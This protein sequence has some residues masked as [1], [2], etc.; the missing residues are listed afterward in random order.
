MP[1]F[2]IKVVSDTKAAEENLK[3]LDAT[4]NSATKERKL[5]IDTSGLVK[6]IEGIKNLDIGKLNKG[7]N[8]IQ[9][10]VKEAANTIQQFY[11]IGKQLPT[12]LGDQIRQYEQLAKGTLAVAKAAPEATVALKRNAEA[13]QILANSYTAA[14]SGATKLVENLAKVGFAM[15]GVQQA[16]GLVKGA[17]QGFF[18]ETIGREIQFRETLLKTQTTLAST[19]KVFKGNKEITDP[20]EK[21]VTL[22]GAIKERIKSIEDRSI[23]LAGVTSNDVVEVFGIISSQIGN[24]GGGL[25]EA[26]D[27]AISF[28]A[29]LGTFGIPLYQARQEIGSILRGQITEDSYL[30]KALGI[31]S[32]DVQKAK[33]QTGGVVAFIQKKLEASVAGQKIAAKGFSGITSNIND[34]FQIFKKSFGAGL[35]DP[36]LEGLSKTYN[37]LSSLKNVVKGISEEL[38]KSIGQLFSRN[39]SSIFGGSDLFKGLSSSTTGFAEQFASALKRAFTSLQADINDFIAPV[40]NLFEELVKSAGVL[41][42]G[43]TELGKGFVS[44]KIEE[45]KALITIFSNLSEIATVFA[46][47]LSQVL[48]VYGKLLQLPPVQAFAQLRAEID[49]LDKLGVTKIIQFGVVFVGLIKPF[50]LVVT[51]FRTLVAKI[52]GNLSEIIGKVAAAVARITAMIEGMNS[53]LAAATSNVA[54]TAATASFTARAKAKAGASGGSAAV[55]SF[56][57]AAADYGKN[58]TTQLNSALA[59]PVVGKLQDKFI[60]IGSALAGAA[61]PAVSALKKEVQSLNTSFTNTG[62]I[63]SGVYAKLQGLGASVANNIVPAFSRVKDNVN[64]LKA[65]IATNNVVPFRVTDTSQASPAPQTLSASPSPKVSNFTGINIPV[66]PTQVQSSYENIK[67]SAI[68]VGAAFTAVAAPAG[69]AKQQLEDVGSSSERAAQS[70]QGLIG[71]T[72]TL[73]GNFVQMGQGLEKTSQNLQKFSQAATNGGKAVSLAIG[74]AAKAMFTFVKANLIML[75]IQVTITALINVF[76]HFQRQQEAIARSRKAEDAL[77]ELNTKYKNVTESSSEA[78]KA[79][80]AYLESLVSGEYAA[81]SEQLDDL[82]AKQRAQQGPNIF[83]QMGNGVKYLIAE[84]GKLFTTLKSF[85]AI[86]ASPLLGGTLGALLASRVR[87]KQNPE[88]PIDHKFF[89]FDTRNITDPMGRHSKDGWY[90]QELD[91]QVRETAA[92]KAR[93]KPQEEGAG[94][95]NNDVTT[96]AQQQ[97][98]NLERMQQ[99]E[100]EMAERRRAFEED[101]FDFRKSQEDVIF[102]RR[103]ALAQKE[104]DI[105]RASGELRIAQMERSNAKALEGEEGASRA[106]LEALNTYLFER[107]KGELDIEAQKKELSLEVVKVERALAD[108]RLSQ[109][110][111]IAEIRR[112]AEKYALD[113]AKA[114]QQLAA[115]GTASVGGGGSSYTGPGSIQNKLLEAANS[116]LGLFAGSSERCADAM[117]ELFEVAGVA[118]GTTKKAWD[119]LE[120]GPSLA[121]SFFGSDI[122]QKITKKEDLRPGDL[123]GFDRTYGNWKKGVQTHVGMYAGDN[124]MYDHSSKSGLVKRSLDTFQGKFLYGVRPNAY[125][126]GQS[127]NTG[128]LATPPYPVLPPP[129]R[130]INNNNVKADTSTLSGKEQFLI[131]ELIRR[132]FK[133]VQIAAIMGS[134]KTES[135]LNPAQ[136]QIGGGDGLGLFQWSGTRRS[137]VPKITGDYATDV[138]NQLDLF[139]KELSTTHKGAGDK[140]KSATTLEA[141]GAGMKQFEL[142]GKAG[143]RYEYMQDYLNRIQKGQFQG[144]SAAGGTGVAGSVNIPELPDFS[145]LNDPQHLATV[146]NLDKAML[147]MG[148]KLQNLKG[149]LNELNN[150]TNFENIGK[151]F[152]EALPGKESF[153]DLEDGLYKTKLTIQ[154]VAESVDQAY[155]PEHADLLIEHQGHLNTLQREFQQI[156]DKIAAKTDLDGKKKI[157]IQE[158]LNKVSDAY[159]QRQEKIL[160]Y[161]KQQLAAERA[162]A[163]IQETATR[164]RDLDK[165]TKNV[166]DISRMQFSG[167]RQEDINLATDI[168]AMRAEYEEKVGKL[169]DINPTA[170]AISASFVDTYFDT[171][172][173]TSPITFSKP[174]TPSPAPIATVPT[175]T[176]SPI[177]VKP[178]STTAPAK[179]VTAA[180]STSASPTADAIITITSSIKSSVGETQAVLTAFAA[181]AESTLGPSLTGSVTDLFNVAVNFGDA[182]KG[183]LSDITSSSQSF[184]DATGGTA[185]MAEAHLNKQ[186][187]ARI[188]LAEAEK[189]AADPVNNMLG[190]WRREIADTRGQITSLGGTIQSEFSNAMSSSITGVLQGTTTVKEA[191][192]SMFQN[193]GDSFIKMAMDTLSKAVVGDFMQML[194]GGVGGGMGG[195]GGS[196]GAGGMLSGLFSGLFGGARA[197]GGNAAYG[198]PLIV[199]ERGPEIFIPSNTGQIIPNHRSQAYAALSRPVNTPMFTASEKESTTAPVSDP[200]AVNKHILASIATV[201]QKRNTERA[202]TSVGSSSEIKYSRVNSG[203]L[204]FVT[205]DDALKI[206]KQAEINGAKMGQQRTLAALRNNPSTRRGIGI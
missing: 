190:Q 66:I 98:Q 67:R 204:P 69:I 137:L 5:A 158:M 62:P 144:V 129:G 117:R 148:E 131:S 200:F 23:D 181:T 74:F 193:I 39:L 162:L 63:V 8:D 64:S 147:S 25:K 87:G 184:I 22:T 196:G 52:T 95:D 167:M 201:S 128:T 29:A 126:T 53:K 151:A 106:A 51:Y 171:N 198:R 136:K 186:I 165:Q 54:S 90:A 20:Y 206:A 157:E 27:L 111:R 24:I 4:A 153:D 40:R 16:V 168:A 35:L 110:R 75:A 13:G 80:K 134:A 161:K 15:Y 145:Q 92:R 100:R 187:E 94:T 116:K 142:Y 73:F 122:G 113:A 140:L 133:D 104:I 170:K 205:E 65:G 189:A 89:G 163:Y 59:A 115:D 2:Q 97:R 173:Y 194:F 83:E 118:I 46:A 30:A 71:S 146:A 68:E 14:S 12:P 202:L 36:L 37:L 61:I 72:K 127:A 10:N 135:T 149:A 102:E 26:E 31:T 38:G 28:S 180:T 112:A 32:A 48:Q 160:S 107:E 43:F 103:Q 108:Y 17:F 45:F 41:L 19:S 203:D 55:S 169:N 152:E 192:G 119:G 49:I 183:M 195:M 176:T 47:G 6:S 76:G 9:D 114:R 3:R 18:N 150:E 7:F 132:G 56:S 159:I 191:F 185:D 197:S 11:R 124:M 178:A 99:L 93:F 123:V 166:Q 34:L 78:E 130:A 199:G 188:R 70:S 141:A 105:F 143:R 42:K 21:I 138:R 164:T 82:I 77:K 44:I 174:A 1:D 177:T 121:S 58:L 60:N 79:Q 120:S 50:K 175:A 84:I 156:I 81:L 182:Y 155:D 125:G 139:Q 109:E 88:A 33:T 86:M 179:P 172:T 57:T 91:Q 154:A 85:G 101:L 96:K